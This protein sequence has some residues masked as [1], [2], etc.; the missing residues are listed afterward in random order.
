MAELWD[1][2]GTITAISHKDRWNPKC[3]D[4]HGYVIVANI[5]CEHF[6]NEIPCHPSKILLSLHYPTNSFSGRQF[7]NQSALAGTHGLSTTQFTNLLRWSL[8]SFKESPGNVDTK[9][10]CKSSSEFPSRRSV[11][12]TQGDSEQGKRNNCIT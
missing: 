4:Q 9:T 1:E 7:L 2:V 3:F 5:L 11:A 12:I 10:Y 6:R 8:I